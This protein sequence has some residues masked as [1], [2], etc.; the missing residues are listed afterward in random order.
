MK[1]RNERVHTSDQY[2]MP[3]LGGGGGDLAK[4]ENLQPRFG[5]PDVVLPMEGGAVS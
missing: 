4:R 3:L 5:L 2:Y 1:Q